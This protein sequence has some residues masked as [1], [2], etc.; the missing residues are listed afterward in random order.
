MVSPPYWRAFYTHPRAE[1]KCE[2]R[3]QERE[4]EVFLPTRAVVRQWKDRKKKVVEPLFPN[5]IFA[6]VDERER[7][8][9]LRTSGIVR[10]VAF[11]DGPAVV[12]DEEIRQLQLMQQSGVQVEPAHVPLLERG[13]HVV[14]ERGLLR[15]LK[16]WVE[17][18]RGEVHLV[19]RIQS[20]KQ[21]VR[22]VVPAADVGVA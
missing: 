11:G 13:T 8:S 10:C 21:S 20:I 18:H 4:L 2:S 7:L 15:G 22:V 3:L 14:V 16:G 1:K 19:V 5:Y 12:R 6:R 9:I 17:A